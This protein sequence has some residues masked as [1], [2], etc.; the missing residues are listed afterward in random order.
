MRA[1]VYACVPRP[2]L[3]CAQVDV[4]VSGNTITLEGAR[5]LADGVAAS[6]TLAA[7]TLDNNDLR[8]EGGQVG[9]DA[10]ALGRQGCCGQGGGG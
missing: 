10:V 6:T 4:D 1:C 9:E 7:I 5:L 2:R 8:E 3:L